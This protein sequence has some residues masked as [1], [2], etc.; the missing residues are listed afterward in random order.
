M[1]T[2]FFPGNRRDDADAFRLQARMMSLDSAVM[3]DTLM[4]GA[5]S[6]SYIVITG[7]VSISTTWAS[8]LNSLI[9]CS[10]IAAFSRTNFSWLSTNPCSA[11]SRQSHGGR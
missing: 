3:A 4:P 2:V 8:M 9:A 7:P 10:S 5:N 1:P 11:S 6:I